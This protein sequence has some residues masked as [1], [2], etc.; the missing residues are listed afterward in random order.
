MRISEKMM[1]SSVERLQEFFPGK[2]IRLDG[3]YGGW[4][5]TDEGDRGTIIKELT[6]GGFMTKREVFNEVWAMINALGLKEL[7][8][9]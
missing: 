5:V 6:S 3:A 1:E 2:I 8:V 7:P 9:N 4:K